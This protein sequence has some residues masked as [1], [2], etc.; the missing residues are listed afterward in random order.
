MARVAQ[1]GYIGLSV[2]NVD[3]WEQFATG[4]LGLQAHTRDPDGSLLLRMDDYHHRFIVS[5]GDA[6]DLTLVGWEVA[7]EE[8]LTAIGEQLSANDIAVEWGSPEEAE[9]RRVVGLLKLQ[10]PNG[11]AT[12]IFYGPLVGVDKPFQS[13]PTDFRVY[14]RRDG[15]RPYHHDGR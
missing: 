7:D 9:A 6:D 3:E 10:D 11:L 13:P 2:S 4:V 8:T 14:H 1:L 12:E 15:A 5:P